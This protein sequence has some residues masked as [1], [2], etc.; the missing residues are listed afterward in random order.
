MSK[1][2]VEGLVKIYPFV[3]PGVLGRKRAKKMLDKQREAPFTTN[4]GVIALR[5][6]SFEVEEGEFVVILGESGCGKSTLLR[7]V[8]G[9]TDTTLGSVFIDDQDVTSLKPEERNLS[10][11]FQNYAL[12]PHLTVYDNIAFSLKTKHIPREQI[13]QQVAEVARALKIE[14]LLNRFPGELSGHW[15]SYHS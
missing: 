13:E 6:V 3:K 8:A 7:I 1:L 15:P 11:I 5:E 12:Y 4:E 10:M 14:E 2:R 9:L